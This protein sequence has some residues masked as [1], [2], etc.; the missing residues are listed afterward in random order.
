MT[1]LDVLI[2]RAKA[3]HEVDFV[4]DDTNR[5]VVNTLLSYAAAIPSP[6]PAN[7]ANPSQYPLPDAQ[8]SLKKGIML[9]GG[10][11]VGKTLLM[12]LLRRNLL[13]NFSLM[14]CRVVAAEFARTGDEGIEKYCRVHSHEGICF[15]DLG[16][17]P[18][19]IYF[20][21]QVNVMLEVMLRR[22]EQGAF[23]RTH[24]TTNLTVKE[25][26]VRYGN[27]LTDRFKEMFNI[28]CFPETAMSRR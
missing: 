22:Y 24:V 7:P 25:L 12:K 9:F 5:S 20:G 14:N 15:D 19:K 6:S 23:Y 16:I 10:C 1:N 17:E 21:Q 27:R 3:E 26:A 13:C 11:G 4:M 18:D 28:V 8:Y 2:S